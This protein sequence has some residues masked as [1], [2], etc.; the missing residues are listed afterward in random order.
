M[1]TVRLTICSVFIL[2]LQ[3]KAPGSAGSKELVA[4]PKSGNYSTS[5]IKIMKLSGIVLSIVFSTGLCVQAAALNVFVSIPPQKWLAEKVGGDA[6][7]VHVLVGNG[8]EPHNFSP[9]PRQVAAL[10]RARIYFT[11]DMA[12]ERELVRRISTSS[13]DAFFVNSIAGIDKI[14]ISL[15]GHGERESVNSGAALDPHVWLDPDNLQQMAQNMAVA[16]AKIDP[17]HASVYKSNLQ[18]V[19]KELASLKR[20]LLNELAPCAGTTFYVFHP[21]FGYFAHAFG[22]KQKA[23]EASGKSPEPRQLRALIRQ[24]RQE[25]I[26][27]I[28]VQPQFDVKSARAVASA[29]DG[30]MVPLDPLAEDVAASLRIMAKEI[31]AFCHGG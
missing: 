31:G 20:E 14:P 10:Y 3:R 27:V 6:V 29:I 7:R 11:I 17:G 5:M 30:T 28:F 18:Q 16:L 23:V 4:K 24:A 21:A 22:L 15:A 19:S 2:F 26:Q 12:F 9:T 8:Q 1:F 25:K 13:P